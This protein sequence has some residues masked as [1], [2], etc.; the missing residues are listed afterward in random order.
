MRLCFE[1]KIGGILSSKCPQCRN[2]YQLNWRKQDPRRNLL[3]HARARAR[4]DG[5]LCTLCLADIVIP[6]ECPVLHIP[7]ICG[8]ATPADDSPSI[9]RINNFLGYIVGNIQVI[10]VK[11]NRIKNDASLEELEQVVQ[12]MRRFCESVRNTELLE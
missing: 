11:A 6:K 2:K 7:L 9:D 10:S 3:W 12:Y 5:I 1:H 8:R 4:R